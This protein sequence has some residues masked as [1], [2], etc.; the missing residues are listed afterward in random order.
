MAPLPIRL[1]AVDIDGTLLNHEFKVSPEDAAAMR[2]A[3]AMGVEIVVA[4]GR[5]HQFALHVV[6]QLGVDLC[7]I[8]SN[9]AVTRSLAGERFHR[10]LLPKEVCR[11]LCHAMDKFRGH[12]V[13]T[14]DKETKGCLV[15][16]HLDEIGVSIRRWLEKNL[17]YIEFVVPIEN[18]LVEDPIQAMFCG[19]LARM[20]E[21]QKTLE[22]SGLL[23][24]VTVL[25]TE[26]PERDLSMVDILNHGC[27]KGQAL[28]RWATH[29][30]IPREQVMA[31][32]DNYNDVEMLEYA[33]VPV[34][35]GNASEELRNRGW[36][37]TRANSENG[38]AA[39]LEEF[40]F[41]HALA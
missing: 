33:G 10:N 1:L 20:A 31:I 24:R 5:R 29:R 23:D 26:Y 3:H 27:T 9:G 37:E 35:M 11:Q 19:T 39:A 2:Q 34:I 18:A 6:E 16:E 17:E 32:G 38:V 40:L 12:M 7:M 4:T 36:M 30:G 21:V 15:L 8:S 25:R 22:A 14:F 28:E 41:R 13:V